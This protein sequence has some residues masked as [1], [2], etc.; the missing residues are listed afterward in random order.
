MGFMLIAILILLAG[1]F[2]T[3]S[4]LWAADTVRHAK[5]DPPWWVLLWGGLIGGV[6]Y[7]GT[8]TGYLTLFRYLL[9]G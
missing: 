1:F 6:I 5:I 4:I 9:A 8:I 7:T 2:T 3:L